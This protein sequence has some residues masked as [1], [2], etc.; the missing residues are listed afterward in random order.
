MAPN[1]FPST[2]TRTSSFTLAVHRI[3]TS[4]HPLPNSP[5]PS[6]RG[7]SETDPCS[8]DLGSPGFGFS[9]QMVLIAEIALALTSKESNPCPLLAQDVP[10][11]LNLAIVGK[12]A[13][14][15]SRGQPLDSRDTG[16]E[17]KRNW[18]GNEKGPS[19]VFVLSLS[20]LLRFFQL[21]S[22]SNPN[23]DPQLLTI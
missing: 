7:A 14:F 9:Y 13:K 4:V 5:P 20:V 17:G 23:R 15:P 21:Q 16:T 2:T 18:A 8:L 22:N 3:Q 19:P 10:S 1:P 12:Q 11:V 6:S